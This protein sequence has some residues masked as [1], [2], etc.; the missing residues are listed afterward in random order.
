MKSLKTFLAAALILGTTGAFA[1]K[2]AHT[3]SVQTPTYNWS[4]TSGTT[5]K[6]GETNPL[7]GATVSQAKSNYGCTGTLHSCATG[8][9]PNN[10]LPPVTISFN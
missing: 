6:P 5:P 7:N 4:R 2:M 3:P 10:I 1:T 9:D 8:I